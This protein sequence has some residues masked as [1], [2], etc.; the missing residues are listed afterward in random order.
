MCSESVSKTIAGLW[1]L[2][3]CEAAQNKKKKER[4]Q[5]NFS[6]LLLPCIKHISLLIFQVLLK[7]RLS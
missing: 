6:L 7:N 5:N 1:Y 2:L 3:L 4:K